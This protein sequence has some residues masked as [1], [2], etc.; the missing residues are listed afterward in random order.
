MSLSDS[1]KEPSGDSDYMQPKHQPS[2]DSDFSDDSTLV[3]NRC[4]YCCARGMPTSEIISV[5][6]IPQA[7]IAV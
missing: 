3:R 2:A 1:G 4:A 5:P 6:T 7:S